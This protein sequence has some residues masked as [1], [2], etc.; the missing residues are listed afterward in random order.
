MVVSRP[1]PKALLKKMFL[2]VL[3]EH[4]RPGGAYARCG[5]DFT[6]IVR[7]KICEYFEIPP[8]TK[9]EYSEGLRAVYELER[10]GYI[11][12]DATQSSDSFKVLTEKGRIVA[13]RSLDEMNLPS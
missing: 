6:G 5:W 13:E 8:L 10:D 9:D 12:Q 7:P 2:K 1:L 4:K 3:H 11:M